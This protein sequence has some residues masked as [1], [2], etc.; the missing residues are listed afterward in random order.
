MQSAKWWITASVMIPTLL[1]I[2][3]TSIANVALGH[4]Q[5]SLSAGQDEVTWVLTSYLVANAVIIP[6]SGWLGRVM[7]RKN[8][9]LASVA[10][11]TGASMLCGLATSLEAL[12]FFRILQGMGGGGLQPVSQAILL[13]T[14]PPA[15]RGLAMAVFAMGAVLG[16]ILGPLLGGYITDHASWH[17]IFFINVPIGVIAVLMIQTFVEDPPYLERRQ[18][19]EIVDTVGLTLL[20]VGLGCLQVLLDKGQQEDW[21]ASPAMTTLAVVAAVCLTALVFWELRHPNPVVDLRIFADR[22]FATG[23]V[24]MFFGFFAFFGA[25]VLL[26]MYLQHLMG[27]TSWLAGVVLG[28]S[29]AIMLLILPAVGRLTQKIDARLILCFGLVVSGLSL[30]YMSRFTLEID[31]GTAMMSR[32]IQAIGIACFF[33]PLSYLTMAFVPNERMSNASALF[34]LL[35]NLGGSFGTAFV[36][37][38]LARRA[39]FHQARL[40]EHTTPYDLPFAEAVDRLQTLLGSADQALGTL[41][42]ATLRQAAFMAYMDVFHLQALFFFALAVLMWIVRRPAHGAD[43]P[44]AH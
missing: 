41:Y 44:M 28:P 18:A 19:G 14:F 35:R 32:N 29:G 23:N 6:M 10:V 39:Q 17:W 7:G 27:Y 1:E 38:M 15:E 16:P 13:E 34:N 36:T 43:M 3:D 11:F 40:V 42:Q 22:N 26:P 9:L 5:G 30:L 8:Y 12:I 25:I 24:V 37:T 4:I 20:V 2:L 21:F 31:I 33:V